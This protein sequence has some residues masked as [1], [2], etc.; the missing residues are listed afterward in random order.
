LQNGPTS[1]GYI[2]IYGKKNSLP[3]NLGYEKLTNGIVRF[4]N[5]DPSRLVIIR[6]EEKDAVHIEFWR[7]PAGAETPAFVQGNWDLTVKQNKPFVL[8]GYSDGDGICPANTSVKLF[9]DYLTANPNMR[10]HIVITGKPTENFA[11]AEKHLLNQLANEH[12]ICPNRL[13]FF[14]VKDKK[15][16]YKFTDV[17]FWLVPQ[18]KKQMLYPQH[19]INNLKL[20]LTLCEKLTS[21]N[22]G[23]TIKFEVN[24]MTQ[25]QIVQEFKNYPKA[26]KSVV[27][28]QLLRI[29]ADDLEDTPQPSDSELSIEERK[30]IVDSLR[31]IAAV[32]G[33]T[34]PTDEEIKEDYTNYL[35]EKYK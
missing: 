16:P 27:I 10:A 7:V 5:L 26:Q 1:T 31:G 2:I 11:N 22:Y 3:K 9:A 30:A 17:E 25:Q 4:R 29:F 12:K 19:F 23:D 34:P 14:Y 33:K 21:N 24:R 35:A 20:A 28:R 8:G 6:G 18:K 32:E 13:K 15:F